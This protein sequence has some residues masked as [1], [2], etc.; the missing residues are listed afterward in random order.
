MFTN[1]PSNDNNNTS[2]NNSVNNALTGGALNQRVYTLRHI[3][4]GEFICLRQ[5]GKEHL[6]CFSDGDSALQFRAELGLLEHVDISS[7]RLG[8]TPFD[9]FWL[10][11]QMTGRAASGQAATAN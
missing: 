6:A 2:N 4:T 1:N 7:E 3:E 8:D 11:G 10:N 9:R 5:D